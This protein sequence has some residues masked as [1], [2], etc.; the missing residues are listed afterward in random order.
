M[1]FFGEVNGYFTGPGNQADT[2]R[3]QGFHKMILPGKIFLNEC[4][5]FNPGSCVSGPQGRNRSIA[6]L[7]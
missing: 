1:G 2:L 6:L 4:G 5:E 3:S 7:Y